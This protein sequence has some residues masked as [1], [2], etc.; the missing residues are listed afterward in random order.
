M[1][2]ILDSVQNSPLSDLVQRSPSFAPSVRSASSP[3]PSLRRT[4]SLLR[5]DEEAALKP[6][7]LSELLEWESHMQEKHSIRAEMQAIFKQ[8]R[9]LG[10]AIFWGICLEVFNY[11]LMAMVCESSYGIIESPAVREIKRLREQDLLQSY[12]H[13]YSP[14]DWMNDY[15]YIVFL[16]LTLW[17][18]CMFTG[19]CLEL[20]FGTHIV[21]YFETN[22]SMHWLWVYSNFLFPI[23]TTYACMSHT[24]L[25][26]PMLVFGMFK[27]GF[28]EIN[29]YLHRAYSR[30]KLTICWWADSFNGWGTLLHHSS[31][32]WVFVSLLT[33]LIT[34]ERYLFLVLLIVELQHVVAILRYIH[35]R[36]YVFLTLL[37]EFWFEVEI[38]NIL[39]LAGEKD[40][41]FQLACLTLLESH[42][43]YLI[44]GALEKYAESTKKQTLIPFSVVV[45]ED[46]KADSI[47]E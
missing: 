16:T 14:T 42:W 4:F 29:A 30:K 8:A 35:S 46:L 25:S 18:I 31:A 12:S 1:I 22:E 32:I 17:I 9:P 19:L 24:Y 21:Q 38:I 34:W 10:Y 5:L 13:T 36:T 27:F 11:F 15:Q 26:A 6:A 45:G 20:F 47:Q 33:K 23:L 40:F 39:Y 41:T 7:Q 3:Q 37:L 28:P 43:M 44:G 2:S